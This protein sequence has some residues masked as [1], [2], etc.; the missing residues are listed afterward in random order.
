MKST[1]LANHIGLIKFFLCH[2]HLAK[3]GALPCSTTY[4]FGYSAAA[5]VPAMYP[6]AVQRPS[7]CWLKPPADS[8]PQ[9]R[10]GITWPCMSITWHLALILRPARVSCTSG[11]AQA[12]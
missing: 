5:Y 10:P 6:W 3:A 11:V 1:L 2:E 12:A 9:Y 4:A 7:P 8:P